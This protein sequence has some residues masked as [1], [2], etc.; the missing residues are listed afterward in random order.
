MHSIKNQKFSLLKNCLTP[1]LLASSCNLLLVFFLLCFRKSSICSNKTVLRRFNCL[2]VTDWNNFATKLSWLYI[3][4][5]IISLIFRS[6][7]KILFNSLFFFFLLVCVCCTEAFVLWNDHM[8]QNRISFGGFVC[9]FGWW[10]MFKLLL[11]L[12]LDHILW[13]TLCYGPTNAPAPRQSFVFIKWPQRNVIFNVLL[14]FIFLSFFFFSINKFIL[15]WS[16]L[17]SCNTTSTK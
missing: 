11:I 17:A 6:V 16:N 7:M 8:I 1:K 10:S 5:F 3:N 9:L 12:R 2:T 13:A 14:I 15:R 4:T